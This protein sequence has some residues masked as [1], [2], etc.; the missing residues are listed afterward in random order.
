VIN[1]G[2]IAPRS[3]IKQQS[4]PT[5]KADDKTIHTP[6]PALYPKLQFNK[7]LHSSP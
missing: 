6:P 3:Q 2:V 5:P 7:S 1:F 4:N